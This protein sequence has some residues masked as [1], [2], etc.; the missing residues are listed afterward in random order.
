[1]FTHLLGA[2]QI[3]TIYNNNTK[4]KDNKNYVHFCSGMSKQKLLVMTPSRKGTGFDPHLPKASCSKTP[5]W[6]PIVSLVARTDGAPYPRAGGGRRPPRWPVCWGWWW[7]LDPPG[8]R[9]A[10]RRN[11]SV[12]PLPSPWGEENKKH[13]FRQRLAQTVAQVQVRPLKLYC[14]FWRWTCFGSIWRL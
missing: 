11:G 8:P 12:A 4:R 3:I 2:L 7:S 9:G 13:R 1:M 6:F 10:C 5:L 14:L